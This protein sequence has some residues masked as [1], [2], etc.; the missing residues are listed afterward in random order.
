MAIEALLVLYVGLG[1]QDD[2]IGGC[3]EYRDPFGLIWRTRQKGNYSAKV[4]YN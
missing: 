4:G 1:K 3:R 2:S